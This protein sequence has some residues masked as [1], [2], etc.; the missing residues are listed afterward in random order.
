MCIRDRS[1][2]IVTFIF[3]LSDKWCPHTD[4]RSNP[5]S[6]G[7][8]RSTFRRVT[9]GLNR[10]V[11]WCR[12]VVEPAK[13]LIRPNPSP[14]HRNIRVTRVN[15]LISVVTLT[16]QLWHLALWRTSWAVVSPPTTAIRLANSSYFHPPTDMLCGG[17]FWIAQLGAC[18]A[19]R[20]SLADLALFFS[21]GGQ[22]IS[23]LH[24]I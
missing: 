10:G 23:L 22:I 6:K 11:Y 15:D 19:V 8:L 2:D 1:T 13:E 21:F 5:F 17:L 12:A 4:F 16:P 14:I 7:S 18:V 20:L 3:L 24:K 9:H